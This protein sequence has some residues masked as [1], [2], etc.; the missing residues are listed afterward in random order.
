M[1]PPGTPQPIA[2][3][4]SDD[5]KI[6]LAQPE[7]KQKFQDIASYTRPM[8]PAELLAYVREEQALWKPVIEQIGM[9]GK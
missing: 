3:K 6:V 7:L 5:L 1:A 2:Q 9:K 4:I 8:N